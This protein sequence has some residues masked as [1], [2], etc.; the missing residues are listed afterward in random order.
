MNKEYA[1]VAILNKSYT[2][3]IANMF[4]KYHVMV[5]SGVNVYSVYGGYNR[6]GDAARR[7]VQ[8][9]DSYHCNPIEYKFANKAYLDKFGAW[10]LIEE[11]I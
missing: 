7:L 10:N 11:V 6:I 9:A 2:M 5:K 4:D 3:F 8:S 1:V